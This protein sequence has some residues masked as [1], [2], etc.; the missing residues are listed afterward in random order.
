MRIF[1]C[2]TFDGHW[3]VGTAAV[4]VAQNLDQAISSLE[5]ALSET[6]LPQ[7]ITPEDVK[8]VCIT[9]AQVIILNDGNY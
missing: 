6:G 2:T 3:P 5:K 7:K 9:Q 1:T 4:I 8:E